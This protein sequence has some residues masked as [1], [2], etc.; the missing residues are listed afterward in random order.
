V[1]L[2]V[3]SLQ[4]NRITVIEGLQTLRNLRELY[5]SHNGI[6]VI[7]GLEDLV[8][9]CTINVAIDLVITESNVLLRISNQA[10]S[11]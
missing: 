8:I 10:M 5:L 6:K 2:Q 11:C 1:N 9:F 4:S 3:L 7:Q